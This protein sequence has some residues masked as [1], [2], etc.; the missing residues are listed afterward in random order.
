MAYIWTIDIRPATNVLADNAYITDT[1]TLAFRDS[2][3]S[4]SFTNKKLKVSVPDKKVTAIYNASR[5][6][7]DRDKNTASMAI[8]NATL[9]S[10]DFFVH[11][12]YSDERERK[13]TLHYI[14]SRKKY[15]HAQQEAAATLFLDHIARIHAKQ[16]RPQ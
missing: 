15:T 14:D 12:N 3:L 10:V 1:L 13:A 2:G 6:L 9:L 11:I 8:I 5:E 16:L 4:I 7:S